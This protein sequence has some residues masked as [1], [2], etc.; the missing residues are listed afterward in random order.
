MTSKTFHIPDIGCDGCVRAIRNE[1]EE[2]AGVQVLAAEVEGRKCDR[3]LGSAR[4][5]AGHRAG[6]ERDRL[7]AGRSTET[8]SFRCSLATCNQKHVKAFVTHIKFVDSFIVAI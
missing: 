8:G 4:Y 7:R 1:L 2:M 5:R 3:R 6:P